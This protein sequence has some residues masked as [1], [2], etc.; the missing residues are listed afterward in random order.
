MKMD[1]GEHLTLLERQVDFLLVAVQVILGLNIPGA[2]SEHVGVGM[3]E[4]QI[5]TLLLGEAR[6]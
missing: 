3:D 2:L 1:E 5:I 6:S 4:G